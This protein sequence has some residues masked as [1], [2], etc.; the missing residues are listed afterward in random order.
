MIF[1]Q[2]PIWG[3]QHIKNPI[4]VGLAASTTLLMFHYKFVV[5]ARGA[6]E[7]LSRPTSRG[8]IPLLLMQLA[9]GLC[10]GWVSFLVMATA[11]FAGEMLDI[12]MGLSA[13]AQADPS[14]LTARST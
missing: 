3:S 2:A 11:Q 14:S 1:V 9:V 4:L 6:A 8:Y 12:Q 10:I 5:S 7:E 13:A